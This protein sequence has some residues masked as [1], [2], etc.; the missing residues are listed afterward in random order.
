MIPINI[1]VVSLD[2]SCNG[3][4]ACCEG[5]L[6]GSAH[7]HLYWR[8]R[9]CHYVG[10]QGCTIY[11]SRPVDPCQTYRCQWLTNNFFPEWMKPVLSKIII[12]ERD[13]K[14]IK[15]FEIVETGQKMDSTILS[16]L[17]IEHVNGN[18]PNLHYMIDGGWNLIGTPEFVSAMRS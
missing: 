14:G 6:H 10:T 9:K 15:Y 11:E 12:T 18:L 3:C 5:W 1:P 16:W 7:E 4:T 17:F 13:C 8:G 2:R